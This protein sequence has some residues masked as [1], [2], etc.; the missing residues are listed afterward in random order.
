[1]PSA[2][3]R[4]YVDPTVLTGDTIGAWSPTG[5]A[6]GS[7]AAKAGVRTGLSVSPATAESEMAQT[8]EAR[9]AS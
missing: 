4:T 2:R 6:T 8:I 1:M 9:I 3:N 5:A 7:S